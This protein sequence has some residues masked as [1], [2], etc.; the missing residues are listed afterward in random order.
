VEGVPAD[1]HPLTRTGGLVK[2]GGEDAGHFGTEV[3]VEV[4]WVEME[5]D[6]VDVV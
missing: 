4:G 1:G 6:P 5:G 3:A 2:L